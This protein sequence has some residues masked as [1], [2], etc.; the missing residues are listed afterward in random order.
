MSILQGRRTL[1][2]MAAAVAAKLALAACLLLAGGCNR[3]PWEIKDDAGTRLCTVSRA[4]KRDSVLI[5]CGNPTTGGAL[6]KT[7]DWSL[8]GLRLCS[9]PADVYGCTFVL[10]DCDG[11][12][13]EVT[14]GWP[15]ESVSIADPL[16][17]K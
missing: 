7:G 4:M 8:R 5:A 16:D 2:R 3:G 15:H 11:L 6:R 10:Y 9:A 12:L 14:P 17:C 13:R 1:A